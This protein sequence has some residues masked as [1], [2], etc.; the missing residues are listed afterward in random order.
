MTENISVSA[1]EEARPWSLATR[2]IFRFGFIYWALYCL[3]VGAV[4]LVAWWKWLDEGIDKV[5]MWPV[6]WVGVHWFHLTGV[7]ASEHPTGSGDTA[8]QYV[9]VFC[10]LVIALV[11]TTVWSAISEVRKKRREYRTL[12]A[13][14]RLVIRFTLA[15]TLFGYGF[16]KLFH[17]QFGPPSLGRLTETYGDSSPM[18]LLWTFMGGSPAY[19]IFG[20]IAEIIPAILLC[21]RET[22][23]LGALI[24]AAVMGNVVALNFCYDVPVKL[25]ATHLFVMALFLTLPDIAGLWR[26]FVQGRVDGMRGAPIP[27]WERRPLRI[28]SHCLQVVVIGHMLYD[29]GWTSYQR[30]KAEKDPERPALYGAWVVDSAEGVP[31]TAHWARFVISTPASVQLFLGDATRTVYKSAY[32]AKSQTLKIQPEEGKPNF[33]HWTLGSDGRLT[34]AGPVDGVSSSVTM[35]RVDR[36]AYPLQTRGFHWVQEYPYNR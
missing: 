28:A 3:D 12:Y 8:L 10:L 19:T 35:H 27:R 14:L 7:A 18:A 32:D 31:S 22:S 20:G 5:V 9:L 4:D 21:F 6:T 29:A 34:L 30:M 36:T 2:I 25:Y 17:G 13:W 33:L 26:I 16:A 24:A 11:G 1:S 23:T 15:A